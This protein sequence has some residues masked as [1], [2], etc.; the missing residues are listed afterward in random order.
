MQIS[1]DGYFLLLQVSLNVL[2][3]KVTQGLTTLTDSRRKFSATSCGQATPVRGKIVR[4]RTRG[5]G[6]YLP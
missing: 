2:I 1:R 4:R 6:N 5:G 3:S